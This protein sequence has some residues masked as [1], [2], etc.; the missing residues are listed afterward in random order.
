MWK[1][2]KGAALMQVLLITMILAGMAMMLLRAS[3]SRNTSARKTRRSTSATVLIEACMAEVNAIWSAKSP[4]AFWKDY[5]DGNIYCK[6]R[7][8]PNNPESDCK[9]DQDVKKYTC[10]I[11]NGYGGKYKVEAEFKTKNGEKALTYKV[12]DGSDSL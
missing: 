2:N 11:D 12:T 7:T 1:N 3:L 6:E 5:E 9:K 8:D 4:E 10:E